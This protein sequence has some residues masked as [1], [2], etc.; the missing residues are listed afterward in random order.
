MR[1]S[2]FARDLLGTMLF[3]VILLVVT[4]GFILGEKALEAFKSH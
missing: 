1:R 4:F 3:F 2:T